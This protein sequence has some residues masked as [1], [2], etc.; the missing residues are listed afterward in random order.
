MDDKLIEAIANAMEA[1]SAQLR[2]Y[3]SDKD[4]ERVRAEAEHEP[5]LAKWYG[6][7]CGERCQ[8]TN[9]NGLR[10]CM[11]HQCQLIK[12]HIGRHYWYESTRD[13]EAVDG[14]D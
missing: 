1:A 4:K 5:D 2:L 13:R 7:E 9:D 3:L 8:S 11:D 10:W 12:G 14:W 6:P